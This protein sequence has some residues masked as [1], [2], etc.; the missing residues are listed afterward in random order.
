[1]LY[2]DFNSTSPVLPEVYKAMEPYLTVRFGNPSSA[3]SELGRE[4]KQA[5]EVARESVARL[6]GA[7]AEE[8]VFVS[9]GTESCFHALVGALYAA[10]AD[11]RNILYSAVEHP[12]VREAARF[13]VESP[14]RASAKELS[15]DGD[16][17]LNFESLK[18]GLSESP[19]LVSLMLANNETGVIFP[20]AEIAPAIRDS[21]AIYHSDCTQ[22]V[23]KIAVDFSALGLDLL[24]LSGHKFGAHKGVGALV[25]RSGLRWRGPMLGGGQESGRRGGTE[26]VDA[27]VGLGEAARIAGERLRSGV[28][29]VARD[30]F[31]K[32]LGEKVSG[33]KI[34]GAGAMRLPNT[35]SVTIPGVLGAEVVE[36]LAADHVLIAAGSAC[37]GTHPEPSRVLLAMGVP[38]TECLSTVRVSFGPESTKEEGRIV[39]E[40]IAEVVSSLREQA[41]RELESRLS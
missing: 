32:A 23:G 33:I 39:A 18:L 16:G 19:V 40:K 14:F 15:V 12:A 38:A 30:C 41:G 8:V 17:G 5:V 11:E 27:I 20:L 13:L 3:S 24:S 37:K 22:A 6:L 9:N 4:A 28:H 36:R 1:M 2:A 26:A 25:V 7:K 35:A 10:A 31:E 34:N 29:S 21:G